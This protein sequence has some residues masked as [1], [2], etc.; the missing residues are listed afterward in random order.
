M[1][2]GKTVQA[3]FQNMILVLSESTVIIGAKYT[4]ALV[5]GHSLKFPLL[6]AQ[7]LN[8]SRFSF[9]MP[10]TNPSLIRHFSVS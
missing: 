3:V 10:K 9:R 5:I 2:L 1:E 8:C 7:L 6:S 4:S